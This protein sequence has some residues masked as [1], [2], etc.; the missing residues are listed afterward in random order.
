MSPWG[1]HFDGMV[2]DI[3]TDLLREGYNYVA[4]RVN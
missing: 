2:N 1:R 3:D 4:I